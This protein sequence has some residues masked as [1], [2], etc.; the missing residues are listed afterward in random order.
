MPYSV[1]HIRGY[2]MSIDLIIDEV[3]HNL[4]RNVVLA[5]FFQWKFTIFPFIIYLYIYLYIY[6]FL[7]IY[8]GLDTF[9]L[10]KY[11]VFLQSFAH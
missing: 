7:C 3:N 9:K 6:L 1:H 5:R 11:P 10:G 2:M 8:L 4:L